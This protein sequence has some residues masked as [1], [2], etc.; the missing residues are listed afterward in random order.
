MET[1]IQPINIFLV[2]DNEA[3]VDLVKFCLKKNK[4]DVDLSVYGNG[5]D[6]LE[7]LFDENT[8]SPQPDIILL[9]INLPG[10]SGIDVLQKIKENDK[11]KVIPTV[12]LT[13]SKHDEDVIKSYTY[14]A[15]CYLQKPLDLTSFQ[16]IITTFEQFW[17]TIVT[18]PKKTIRMI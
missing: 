5:Q 1:E 15:N 2:E 14:H 8:N 18:L 6:A 9:D 12:M 4:L 16:N 10:M 7:R 11:T 13:S 3:D 17:L